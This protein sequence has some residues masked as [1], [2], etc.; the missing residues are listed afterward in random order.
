[1]KSAVSRTTPEGTRIMENSL[2]L[3]H[4][5]PF[6]RKLVSFYNFAP[7][8]YHNIPRIAPHSF[9]SEVGSRKTELGGSLEAAIAPGDLL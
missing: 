7:P 8:H 5:P 6:L 4:I 2:F 3:P 9:G 1:M